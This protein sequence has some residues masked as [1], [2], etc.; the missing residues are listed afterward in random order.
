MTQLISYISKTF[1]ENSEQETDPDSIAEKEKQKKV[2]L[3]QSEIYSL[4]LQVLQTSYAESYF[5]RSS[6]T[7]SMLSLL[8]KS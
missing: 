7:L 8:G 5:Y 4:Q 3:L 2:T 6:F 1:R